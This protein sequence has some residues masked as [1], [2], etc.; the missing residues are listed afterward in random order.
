MTELYGLDFVVAYEH[1]FVYIR[2][3]AITLR[4]AL[5]TK[6]KEAMTQ[7]SSWQ[8]INCLSVWGKVLD[9][10][11]SQEQM[12][13]LVYP[14]IQI[15]LG[16]IRLLNS[17][18]FAP[19]RLQCAAMVIDVTRPSRTLVPLASCLADILESITLAKKQKGLVKE[20]DIKCILRVP[21]NM[22]STRIYQETLASSTLSLLLRY[23]GVYANSVAF[24][25]LLIPI[26]LQLKVCM[27]YRQCSASDC[28][29]RAPPACDPTRTL[30]AIA[31]QSPVSSVRTRIKDL[32][33]K[34]NRQADYV[35]LVRFHG[36]SAFPR[37]H[38]LPQHCRRGEPASRLP[39][40]ASVQRTESLCSTATRSSSRRASSTRCARLRVTSVGRKARRCRSTCNREQPCRRRSPHVARATLSRV[41]LAA[42]CPVVP[43][44]TMAAVSANIQWLVR[45]GPVL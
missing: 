21:K 11:S 16:T 30:Q 28:C 37:S 10:Y 7:V 8:H 17:P 14:Y 39:P 38:R 18:R 20:V 24:P 1:A 9:A 27:Q 43:S 23:F 32:L 25:E 31:K 2:Q 44:F 12:K 5:S 29:Q 3:L 36:R 4:S 34:L 40:R 6:N 26:Q 19:L 13:L 42:V 45:L 22:L 15:V 41:T 33:E 35:R